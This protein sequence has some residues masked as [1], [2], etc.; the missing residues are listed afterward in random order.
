MILLLLSL[1]VELYW[2]K[3]LYFHTEFFFRVVCVKNNTNRSGFGWS[4]LAVSTKK[5]Q[6][7]EGK[8][9]CSKS[10]MSLWFANG[11]ENMNFS[12]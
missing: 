6:Y 11:T 12:L 4:H 5:V 10:S 8:S 9:V 2:R 1:D 7:G 3:L